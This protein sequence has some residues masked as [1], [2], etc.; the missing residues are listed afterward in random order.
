MLKYRPA[1]A[2]T[3]RW[4]SGRKQRFAKP[5]YGQKLYR[6]FESPPLRHSYSNSM[7]KDDA[8]PPTIGA[9]IRFIRSAPVPVD[10][11]MGNRPITMVATVM[12]LGRIRLTA[13]SS[14]TAF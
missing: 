10:H 4:L 2:S 14:T 13:P 6:G 12:N 9:A 5:S 11:K 7:T 8:N 1:R 3:E